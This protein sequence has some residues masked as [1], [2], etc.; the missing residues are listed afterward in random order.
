[1]P[2]M[3]LSRSGDA[4]QIAKRRSQNDWCREETHAQAQSHSLP[5]QAV[6]SQIHDA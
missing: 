1:M 5:M 3:H 2:G 6:R 4:A